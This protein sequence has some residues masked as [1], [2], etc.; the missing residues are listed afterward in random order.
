MYYPEQAVVETGILDDDGNL[1]ADPKVAAAIEALES[2]GDPINQTMADSL[3]RQIGS[4]PQTDRSFHYLPY[5]TASDFEQTFLK[6]ILTIP[7]ISSLDLEVYYNGDRA[8]TEFKIKCYR[9]KSGRRLYAGFYTPDFLIIQR[10]NGRIYKV[11]IVETKGE[12]YAKDPAF[13][14]KR[15]FVDTEFVRQ[16]NEASGYRRFAYLYLEDTMS[17]TRRIA[18]TREKIVDFFKEEIKDAH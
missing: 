15:L 1:K 14:D 16:N 11:V 9:K 17:E 3:R 8:L 13:K 12:I 4:H 7:E 10:R 2:I 5:G 18:V 6:E